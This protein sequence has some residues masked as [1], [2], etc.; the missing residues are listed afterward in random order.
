MDV[1]RRIRLLYRA[2]RGETKAGIL[3]FHRVDNVASGSIGPDA[4]ISLSPTTFEKVTEQLATA[5]RPLPLSEV[6]S[7]MRK[8]RAL[9][10]RAVAVTFDDGFRDSLTTARPILETYDVPATFY[11]TSGFVDG[12]ARP[13]EHLLAQY[14]NTVEYVRLQWDGTEK[15]WRL[16]GQQKREDCYRAIKSI[17]K[18]LSSSRRRRLLAN[19]RPRL[20]D[21]IDVSR[22]C[23]K[24]M[25]P[26]E[27]SRMARHPL[28]TI[29]AHTHTH[30]LLSSLSSEEARTEIQ[31]SL[32]RLRE[33]TNSPI[34][35]FSYPYGGCTY[36]T[37]EIAK[38]LGFVSAVTTQPVLADAWSNSPHQLPRIE[39]QR[40]STISEL[41][42]S[43]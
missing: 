32:E 33:M 31:G 13:Y 23:P 4:K 11:V 38:N 43:W 7:R 25:S 21:S 37:I 5:F 16:D 28:F 40:Q 24:Y 26:S 1:F 27:V 10:K 35:H 39:I 6:V 15:E 22:A 19:L 2:L 17:G 30:P 41:E 29:G 20:N 42:Q 12:S 3:L 14:V 36:E 18:P 9:P 34:R 8:G